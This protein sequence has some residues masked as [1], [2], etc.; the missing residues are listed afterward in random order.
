M[1]NF[2]GLQPQEAF[3]ELLKYVFFKERDETSQNEVTFLD[4]FASNEE[5]VA[6]AQEIRRRFTAYTAAGRTVPARWRQE[7]FLLSDLALAKVHSVFAGLRLTNAKLDLRSS[8]LREFLS[9]PV[10]KGLGIFLTPETVVQEIVSAIAPRPG[11]RILDPACG[12]A[13]FLM[14]AGEYAARSAQSGRLELFGVDKNP[15]MI[16]LAEFNCGHLNGAEF[17]FAN[18]DTLAPFGDPTLPTWMQEAAFDAIITNPPFGVSIDSRGYQ[19]DAYITCRD[20]SGKLARK[21]SSEVV[22]LERSFQLLKPGGRLGIVIPRSVVTN[23]GLFHAREQL[24]KLG[25]V[26]GIITLPAETFAATGTQTTTVVLIAEKYG[27]RIG[28]D[29][30][31]R[32][33]IARLDNVGFDLTGRDRPNSQ[34]PGL[35]EQLAQAMASAEESGIVRLLDPVAA[36]QSFA[37][38]ENM[39]GESRSRSAGGGRPLSDLVELACT[40]ATPPRSAYTDDG[41]FLVKVGNLSGSGINWAAR[42]RNFISTAA[43][44]FNSPERLLRA[45]DILLTSSAHMT[46]YIGKKIDIITEIPRQVGGRA[47]F[48][49][50]VML[51]RPKASVDPFL[52]LA[53]LRSAEVV[54]GLQ[55]RVRG[56]TAHL[57]PNDLLDLRVNE[58]LFSSPVLS[59]VAGLLREEAA[60]NDRLNAL[61]FEQVELREKLPRGASQ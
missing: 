12:S 18:A 60:L 41:L 58:D 59:Q 53:Y 43:K 54:Q 55:D 20:D 8:A 48:V 61:A 39:L 7:G 52:L 36:N 9:G 26:L 40:G 49:G 25:A 19:F 24:G 22:F 50:E 10:R 30:V 2:D 23:K 1:R 21:Q 14:E 56:Q 27:E 51:V 57:H 16:Q 47:F 34:L 4:G 13:T 42:D 5:M 17:R 31:I 46:K 45:G 29:S 11:E 32:P 37:D 15:R 6:S 35:G 33:V 28:P 44:R 3:D 38:I